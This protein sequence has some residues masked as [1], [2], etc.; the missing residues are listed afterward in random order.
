MIDRVLCPFHD[1]KTPSCAVYETHFK[2]FGCGATGPI[3]KLGDKIGFSKPNPFGGYKSKENLDVTLPR[4]LKLPKKEIR[5]LELPYDRTGYYIVFPNHPYYIKRMFDDNDPN[6]YRS[7]KGHE[8]PRYTPLTCPD[9]DTVIVIEGQLN[10]ASL[11]EAKLLNNVTIT[12][13]GSAVDLNRPKNVA[14]CLQ[15]SKVLIIVDKDAAGVAAAIQLRDTLYNKGKT[16]AIYAMSED[17]NSVLVKCGRDG[18][19]QEIEMAMQKLRG[20]ASPMQTSGT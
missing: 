15:Y 3:S 19:R 13:P 4:I 7:P 6:K 10:C 14:Y 12:S 2:C 8:K 5:G 16:V 18:V 1:E 20:V 11:Y 9:N 17:F